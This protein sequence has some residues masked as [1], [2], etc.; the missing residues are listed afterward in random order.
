MN[1]SLAA[2]KQYKKV[3]ILRHWAIVRKTFGVTDVIRG[4]MATFDNEIELAFIDGPIAKGEEA[5]SSDIDLLV[6]SQ[7]ANARPEIYQIH[8]NK[9]VAWTSDI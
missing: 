6:R 9:G 5:A 3:R 2:A 7:K 1:E 8:A 4:A